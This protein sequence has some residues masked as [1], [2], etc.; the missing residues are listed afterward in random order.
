MDPVRL[1]LYIAGSTARSERAIHNLRRI[2]EEA[3]GGVYEVE[4][5]DVMNDP[6]AAEGDRILTTPTLIK[7]APLPTRRVTGDL[8]DSEKVL[9]GLA[10]E[11]FQRGN[12]GAESDR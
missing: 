5:I 8:S 9:Y 10:L 12:P 11:S 6:D 4:I 1:K 2:G 3:L 7:E